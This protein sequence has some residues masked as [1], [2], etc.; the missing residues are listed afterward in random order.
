MCVVLWYNDSGK[1]EGAKMGDIFEKI[2]G[3]TAYENLDKDMRAELVQLKKDADGGDDKVKEAALEEINDRFYKELEFGTGG[4]R[5]IL[6]AGSNR[7]NIYTVRKATAGVAKYIN[8]HY[9]KP[10]AAISYDSRINSELFAKTAADILMADGIDIYLYDT[11]MPAPALSFAT[12][13]HKCAIGIMITASHNPGKY[14]GY[15]V[16][17]DQGCQVTEDAADEILHNIMKTDIFAEP[18]QKSG[19][20][21][22]YMKDETKDAFYEAVAAEKMIWGSE[23]E[24]KKDME[25]LSIVY[26]PLNGA[27]N[28][29]VRKVLG[30]LGI[31]N[32]HMVKEQELPDGNFPTCPYPNPE[33]REALAKGL[34]LFREISPD[35]L[36]ATDPD[37]DRI[38]I[39]VN[40][41][42]KELLTTGN[43][44]GLLLFD[45]ICNLRAR[46]ETMPENPVTV[47]T[48]VS[49]IMLDAIAEEYKV[50]VK[51][52]LTGFKY[53]G[54]YIAQLELN[55][56]EKDYIFGFE[57][58]Y[59]YLSGTYVRDKDAV[60]AAM[61]ICQMAAYYKKQGKTLA[62]RLEEL[63]AKYGYYIN[64]L[65]EF[66]F[67]GEKGMNEMKGIMDSLRNNPLVE[68]AGDKVV[69]MLDYEDQPGFPKSNV[70]EARL[71][72]GSSVIARPSGTEPKLKI[73]ISAKGD[74]RDVAEAKV[75][76]LKK[77]RLT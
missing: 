77:I 24:M 63:Y 6:G 61:L 53:I 60:N 65:M 71:E 27:G 12:R 41:G 62:D 22:I 45:F 3:W 21:L 52:T 47:R 59:G 56:R 36:L 64:H 37:S 14:N 8:S 39:A 10:S 42:G 7:M 58:S 54:E 67:E 33:K 13:Y 20:K 25:A 1:E 55:E 18:K 74:T 30:G 34:E 49:S 68:I 57:E 69:R 31:K 51:T 72:S 17:N 76:S 28:I 48:I 70:I 5:G 2:D 35:L 15:K 75:E 40:A 43:E 26:T 4:L 46:S 38:G 29:P 32:I 16:Y 73:Y 50:A 23:E 9:E 66:I 44:V 11:L 19:A